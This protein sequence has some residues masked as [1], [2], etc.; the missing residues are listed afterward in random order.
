MRF[1]KMTTKFQEAF[2]DAQ[3]LALAH[4]NGLI[5]SPHLLAALLAQSDGSTASLLTRADVQVQP[6]KQALNTILERLPKV[7]GGGGE[8]TVSRDLNNLLNVTE[9]EAQKRGDQFIASELFLLAL[10]D[11]KGETGRLFKQQG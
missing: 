6:L 2:A 1:D 8:I 7:E 10:S 3:S 5:E 9:R 4:D 11:D